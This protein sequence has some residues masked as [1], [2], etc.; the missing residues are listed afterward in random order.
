MPTGAVQ[1]RNAAT[2]TMPIEAQ[3]FYDLRPESKFVNLG[4]RAFDEAPLLYMLSNGI[5]LPTRTVTDVE[6]RTLTQYNDPTDIE[7]RGVDAA[8]ADTALT[9]TLTTF[10]VRDIA[11]DITNANL[12]LRTGDIIHIPATQT[13]QTT[14]AGTVG[15]AGESVRVVEVN[16][17]GTIVTVVRGVGGGANTTQVAAGSGNYLDG[18][19]LG[20]LEGE[21]SRSSTP[22]NHPGSYQMQF[23]PLVKEPFEATDA[24]MNI[25]LAGGDPFEIE[26]GKKL[27]KMRE[28]TERAFL[29]DKMLRNISSTDGVGYRMRG[30][31]PFIVGDNVGTSY[32]AAS[33]VYT[34]A[35]DLV[36]GN[37]TSQIW[38]V[39]AKNNFTPDNWEKVLAHIYQEGSSRKVM[40]CGPDFLALFRT[41]FRDYLH[42]SQEAAI[43]G[44]LGMRVRTWEHDFSNEPMVIHMHHM[45][46]GA[47]SQDAVIIDFDRVRK[48][49]LPGGELKIW[50]GKTG[51]GL[52]ENDVETTKWAWRQQVAIDPLN[53]LAFCWIT[54]VQNDDGTYGGRKRT[55]GTR[56]TDNV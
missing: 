22:I 5:A 48:A 37:G 12:L 14:A 1:T 25:I 2:S 52:Q 17:A 35:N 23:C 32:S 3:H 27:K 15:A 16:S 45:M 6:F 20:R 42:L 28:Q 30:V 24:V 11:Q 54:G 43:A 10:A 46:T 18:Y 9:T 56:T 8:G 31:I 21:Q 36:T 47:Y 55:V 34:A 4:E 40:F 39:G 13:N 41:K 38:R 7:I 29:F 26:M 51:V 53:V 33:G 50:K 44:K 19:I 49:T